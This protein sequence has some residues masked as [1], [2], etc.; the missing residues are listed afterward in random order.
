MVA[1]LERQTGLELLLVEPL[2]QLGLSAV[3]AATPLDPKPP[4]EPPQRMAKLLPLVQA[5]LETAL[6]DPLGTI[7]VVCL[8]WTLTDQS[9]VPLE[10][11]PEEKRHPLRVPPTHGKHP[12]PKTQSS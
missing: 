1:W 12:L 7:L 11:E 9:T 6:E 10:A 8:E 4:D 5:P 3:W 2:E